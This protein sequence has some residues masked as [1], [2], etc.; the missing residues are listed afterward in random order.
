MTPDTHRE[1]SLPA[2][3]ESASRARAEVRDWLGEHHP[4]YEQARLAVSELVTNGIR[5]PR[6]S[7]TP[8]AEP[9]VLRLT[10]TAD[11]LRIE[12]TDH[13]RGAATQRLHATEA[14]PLAEGGRGLVIIDHLCEG[15]WDTHPNPT[16]P[17][18]TDWCE[19]PATAEE[20]RL[21][22]PPDHRGDRMRN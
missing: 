16:G 11:R 1:L 12:V 5:H 18:R 9:L 8:D 20:L 7:L 22:T 15:R 6:A 19:L 4:S 14:L 13:G 3:P 17:G 10:A 2:T 21:E